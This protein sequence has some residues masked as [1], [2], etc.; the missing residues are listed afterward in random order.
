MIKKFLTVAALAAAFTGGAAHAD[1]ID[2]SY[3]FS[4][5][6]SLTGSLTGTLS[7][8]FVSNISGISVS[9]D[10]VALTGPL[11]AGTYTGSS[12]TI[13]FGSGAAVFSTN[14]AQNNFYIGDTTDVSGQT[15]T[16]YFYFVNG[17]TPTGSGSQEVAIANSNVLT[18]TADFDNVAF[19]TGVGTWTVTD[20]S[21]VPVPAAL[22][23]M[24]S[25]LGLLA[26]QRRRVRASAT[27]V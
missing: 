6:Q 3:L 22:P 11:Y 27:H 5:G 2:F 1:T 10:G 25:G 23:L 14:A 13:N 17:T 19:G 15:Q 16:N 20:V 9:F 7:N 4:D 24:L 12:G 18:N 26:L 21:A 8:G